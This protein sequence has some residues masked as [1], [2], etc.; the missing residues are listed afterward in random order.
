MVLPMNHF[1]PGTPIEVV[2]TEYPTM[3]TRYD[4]WIDSAGAGQQRGGIGYVREYL[5][6]TDCILTTRTSNHR[7]AAWG[8]AG[9]KES[10]P[11]R[12]TIRGADGT[13]EDME[14][15]ETRHVEAGVSL[16][17]SQSGG[18]GYGNPFARSTELVLQD[19]QDGYV[20]TEAAISEYGVVFANDG[21]VDAAATD[22]RRSQN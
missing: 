14:V 17:L 7:N 22:K 18:G 2:E 13:T 3:V 11:S 20:S 5:F 8:L 12:T 1:A 4:V 21:E 15:M 9:G 6:L 10:K 16:T 19:V